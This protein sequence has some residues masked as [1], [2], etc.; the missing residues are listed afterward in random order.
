MQQVKELWDRINGH[1]T[2]V[3]TFLITLYTF[4]VQLDIVTFN[5]D[6]LTVLAIV[7]GVG[8]GH[9]VVKY[10]KETM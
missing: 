5:P 9:K 8:T 4:A 1:K 7:F 6:V 3:G 2:N 10:V